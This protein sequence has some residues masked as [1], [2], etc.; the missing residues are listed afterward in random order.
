MKAKQILASV[1]SVALL[2]QL[3]PLGVLAL[4]ESLPQTPQVCTVQENLDPVPTEEPA[5]TAEPIPEETAVPMAAPTPEP[6][7]EPTA[8]PAA[9]PAP[10]A[11]ETP[12]PEPS[13]EP[14]AAPDPAAAV[15]ALIDALPDEVTE[16]N[17]EAVEQALTD[18]DDAKQSLTDDELAGL[19][20]TRYDAAANALLA[21]WGEAAT[22]AVEM[23]DNYATPTPGSDG[24]YSIAD[25][26]D[27]RWFASQ[28]NSGNNTINAKLTA[29]ITINSGVL[30]ENGELNTG[31]N[32]TPWTLIGTN[33]N[34]FTGTFDGNNKTISGLYIGVTTD[35]VGLFGCVGNGSTV[36]NVTL[37]DSYVSG[38]YYVGGICGQ[39][40]GGTVQNCHNTG[41]VSGAWYVGGVCG[42]NARLQSSDPPSTIQECYN[43]GKVSGKNYVGGVCGQNNRATVEKSYNT[44]TVSGDGRVGGVCGENN[45]SGTVNGCYNTGNRHRVQ[46]RR[47]VRL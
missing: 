24:Y 39:N 4:D 47:R 34:P 17:A 22:D 25:A 28:V 13:A 26:D 40:K 38:S 5:P 6:T 31:A 42:S 12:A 20:L 44:N 18:I 36:K 1:L 43:T 33:T 45:Y 15:Q 30:N 46:C 27:L 8:T 7:A 9:E 41:K 10:D 2:L 16:D 23:L 3:S 14:T 32:F 19:D 21:L 11:A 35:Y 29:D 37:A